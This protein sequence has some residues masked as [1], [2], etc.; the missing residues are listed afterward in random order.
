MAGYLIFGAVL[1]RLWKKKENLIASIS[2]SVTYCRSHCFSFR[3]H[4]E[5]SIVI[6]PIVQRF[7]REWKPSLH[8]LRV[9]LFFCWFFLRKKR[10]W[11]FIGERKE[12]LVNVRKDSTLYNEKRRYPLPVCRVKGGGIFRRLSAE[13][14]RLFPRLPAKIRAPFAPWFHVNRAHA[15]SD[16]SPQFFGF[17]SVKIG[18]SNPGN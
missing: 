14:R 7:R 12:Y 3:N 10:I 17:F 9:L 8:R 13:Q 18:L 1:C 11:C 15:C 6:G 2:Q 4:I 16:M 5:I